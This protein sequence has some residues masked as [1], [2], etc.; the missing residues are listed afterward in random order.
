MESAVQTTAFGLWWSKA[1]KWQAR[2]VVVTLA[3]FFIA[4]AITGDVGKANVAAAV[5]ALVAVIAAMATSV[6]AIVAAI[7]ATFALA[8]AAALSVV[9]IKT[10]PALVAAAVTALATAVVIARAVEDL[11]KQGISKKA[12]KFSYA[13]EF[14]LILIP[15]LIA[16]LT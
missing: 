5:I 16:M 12:S 10:T 2:M 11:S 8:T 1:G 9:A 4:L 7:V 15:T 3:T 13:T 6:A 14:V